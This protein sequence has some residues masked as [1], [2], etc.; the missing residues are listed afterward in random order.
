VVAHPASLQAESPEAF[1]EMLG[2][3]MARGVR[4]IEAYAAMHRDDEIEMFLRIARE[5]RCLVTGGSDFHGD[6]DEIIGH[7]APGKRIPESLL[8]P[9]MG[10]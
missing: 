2:Q 9:L 1:G 4:G 8:D 6:K 5:H 10:Q 7:Y 3:W